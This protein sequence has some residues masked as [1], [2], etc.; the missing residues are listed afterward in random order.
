M[1]AID[2]LIKERQKKHGSFDKY[3]TVDQALKKAIPDGFR[4]SVPPS[5][6]SAI[7]MIFS[8]I[9]RIAT[10]DPYEPDHW[11]DIQ[12]YARAAELVLNKHVGSCEATFFDEAL[13]NAELF[14]VHPKS[15]ESMSIEVIGLKTCD[16]RYLSRSIDRVKIKLA[17]DLTQKLVD[18]KYEFKEAAE[19]LIENLFNAE[20]TSIFEHC[21]L[22][23]LIRGVSRSFLAQI[24]RQGTFRFTSASQQFQD[25]RNYPMTLRPGWDEKKDIQSEYRTALTNGLNSYIRLVDLG[26]LPEEARQV[27]PPAATANLL[28]TANARNIARFLR[29]RMCK[30]NVKE[31]HLFA[32][33]LHEVCMNWLPELFEHVH[34]PCAMDGKCNQGKFA[35]GKPY[36]ALK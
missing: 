9:A 11:K 12:G 30:R 36:D 1:T 32:F 8:K 33:R 20:H 16:Q 31:M 35:C 26:E 29:M 15:Y 23:F 25:Y 18:D 14:S 4:S 6:T 13:P 21:V 19:T 17:C 34:A 3:A 5:V 2:E 24:T 10:G 28:T 7:E 22:S 27:L